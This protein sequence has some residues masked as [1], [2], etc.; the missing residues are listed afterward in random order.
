M[1]AHIKCI[2]TSFI[3]INFEEQRK[4]QYKEKKLAYKNVETFLAS[5]IQFDD[6]TYEQNFKQQ[7]DIVFKEA[8]EI[9]FSINKKGFLNGFNMKFLSLSIEHSM[10]NN[11]W[12]YQIIKC[13]LKEQMKAK[14][15]ADVSL[16]ASIN[17]INS[18]VLTQSAVNM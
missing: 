13:F 11:Y 7:R 8:I 5:L 18:P 3:N 9:L 10:L 4:A 16:I 14:I 15:V 17:D 1:I 6:K 2:S 12:S